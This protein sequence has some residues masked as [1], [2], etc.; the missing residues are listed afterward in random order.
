VSN[1]SCNIHARFR[2][3]ESTSGFRWVALRWYIKISGNRLSSPNKCHLSSNGGILG[4]FRW[5][6]KPEN[7]VEALGL[8]KVTKELL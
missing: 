2:K 3:T 5:G 4:K 6:K 8:A 1:L 7:A